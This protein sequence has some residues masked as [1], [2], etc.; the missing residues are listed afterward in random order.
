MP[1]SR[2][3]GKITAATR[4][5]PAPFM[6]LRLPILWVLSWPLSSRTITPIEVSLT[7]LFAL[8]QAFSAST[9]S[10]AAS[11]VSKNASTTSSFAM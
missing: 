11:S 7:S 6:A 4:P 1:A 10:S 3:G 5:T 8:S 9:A 2:D